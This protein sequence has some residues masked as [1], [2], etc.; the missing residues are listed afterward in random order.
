[1]MLVFINQQ[2]IQ[3]VLFSFLPLGG[4]HHDAT[5]VYHKKMLP[6]A[7]VI[8]LDIWTIMLIKK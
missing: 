1:M 6:S 2:E 3:N 8:W 5:G 4:W 7:L